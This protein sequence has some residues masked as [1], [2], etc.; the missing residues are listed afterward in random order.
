MNVAFFKTKYD[1]DTLANKCI[2]LFKTHSIVGMPLGLYSDKEI[3]EAIKRLG[4]IVDLA[5]TFPSQKE[6]ATYKLS[7][8]TPN[9]DDKF[10]YLLNSVKFIE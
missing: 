2:E 7:S 4:D 5:V 6:F 1:T 9:E 10:I 3:I 8:I